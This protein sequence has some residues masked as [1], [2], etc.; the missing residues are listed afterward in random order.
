MSW[1]CESCEHRDGSVIVT[2]DDG[3]VFRVCR[4]C[5]S[6]SDYGREV[7]IREAFSQL[8]VREAGAAPA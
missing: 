7:S 2:F 8:L 5:A 6:E 1:K 3:E 4:S